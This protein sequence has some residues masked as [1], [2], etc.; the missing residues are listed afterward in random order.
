MDDLKEKL[1]KWVE[2]LESGN[3]HQ[4]T[5]TLKRRIEGGLAGYCCLGVYESINGREPLTISFYDED[6]GPKE[7]YERIRAEL[8]AEANE[9]VDVDWLISMNDGGSS[10]KE[11]AEYIRKEYL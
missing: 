10:F 8:Y 3:Y 1:T 6:E 2:A 11:I 7:S 9:G 4:T 5:N